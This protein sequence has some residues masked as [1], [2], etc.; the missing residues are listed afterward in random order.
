MDNFLSMEPVKVDLMIQF[1]DSQ[2]TTLKGKTSA[3]KQAIH[4]HFEPLNVP[5]LSQE[6]PFK[7]VWTGCTS[8][9]SSRVPAWEP[10]VVL[11]RCFWL[12]WC[13]TSDLLHNTLLLCTQLKC[14]L[15]I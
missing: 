9:L 4:C 15:R 12:Q 10:L 3:V 11:C 8:P 1:L 5:K 7:D 14:N 2:F 13:L 6:T